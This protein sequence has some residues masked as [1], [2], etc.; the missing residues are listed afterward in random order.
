MGRGETSKGGCQ[1]ALRGRREKEGRLVRVWACTG[2]AAE[3]LSKQAW[4]RQAE[5]CVR[6]VACVVCSRAFRPG[7]TRAA[8]CKRERSRVRALIRAR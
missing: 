6:A 8:S 4:L 1:N 2:D 7:L 5:G 3:R